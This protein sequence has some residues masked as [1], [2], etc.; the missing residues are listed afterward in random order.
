MALALLSK[1]WA[2]VLFAGATLAGY[3][4]VLKRIAEKDFPIAVIAAAPGLLPVIFAGQNGLLTGALVGLFAVLALRS[5]ALAG[6]PLGLMAIKP[7]LALGISVWA[8]L[9]G[10]WR[11]VGVAAVTVALS[12]V[13]ATAAF[14]FG[15]WPAFL[16]GMQATAEVL[17]HDGFQY[18]RLTSVYAAIRSQD[19]PVT[20]ALAGQAL[21][22]LI[23]LWVILRAVWRGLPARAQIG[24]AVLASLIMTPYAYDYDMPLF[25]IGFALLWPE[26]APRLRRIETAGIFA[27]AWA[28]TGW[29]VWLSLFIHGPARLERLV[30]E[31]A[32]PAVAGLAMLAL[33][34]WL[35]AVAGRRQAPG[36][37]AGRAS[38]PATPRQ[39]PAMQA[40]SGPRQLTVSMVVAGL[41]V[42]LCLGFA[43]LRFH[44]LLDPLPG[45]SPVYLDFEDFYLVG[46]MALWGQIADAYHGLTMFRAQVADG[47]HEVFMPWAYPP[48]YD[49]VV[50]GLALLP[51]AW[52]YA[53]LTVPAFLAMLWVM[54]RL[55]GRNAAL[56]VIFLFP[57]Y[58]IGFICG[59]NGF[60]TATLLG[61]AA[62]ASLEGR[63]IAGLPLG[64]MIIKPHLALLFGLHALLRRRWRMLALAVAVAAAASALATLAFGT[65]VWAAFLHGTAEA[66]HY[67]RGHVYPLFRMISV[68]STLYRAGLPAGLALAA[69]L[70]A[71]LAVA[72]AV[73]ALVRRRVDPRISLGLV[74]LMSPAVSPYAYDYDT[75]IL[76]IAGALLAGPVLAAARRI[77]LVALFALGWIVSGSGFVAQMYFAA[78]IQGSLVTLRQDPVSPAGLAYLALIGLVA[79]VL[80]QMGHMSARH[81][82]SS[83]DANAAI[84]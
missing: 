8:L 5:R 21:A 55:A 64:L 20:W 62:M 33:I 6:L 19:V 28:A 71:A 14:G 81:G 27:L 82:E 23:G 58:L 54:V 50:A 31:G 38:G 17:R 24:L 41:L 3:A 16:G 12:A 26:I 66:S 36:G 11:M 59:Q 35:A 56:V 53:V 18:F 84:Y 70:V 79:W 13:L 32:V 22:A 73:I 45:K 2:Y 40:S 65:A 80:L 47:S 83:L 7:H 77:E 42:A 29:S 9:R 49:L 78:H 34:L 63:A 75:A 74:L 48:A 30:R 57:G 44:W 46:R 37:A 67:L 61:L 43:W 69:Q 1:G 60:L 51:K 4:A 52:A 72:G 76:G 39:T 15:I 25:G 68:Y 10:R